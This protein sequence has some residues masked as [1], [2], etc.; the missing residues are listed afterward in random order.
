MNPEMADSDLT[1]NYAGEP[2]LDNRFMLLNDADSV[3]ISVEI[4]FAPLQTSQHINL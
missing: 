1:K 4:L 3:I 2:S